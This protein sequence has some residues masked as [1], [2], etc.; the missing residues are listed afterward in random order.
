[1]VIDIKMCLHSVSNDSPLHP[2]AVLHTGLHTGLQTGPLILNDVC[3]ENI[4]ISF[5]QS[6]KDLIIIQHETMSQI[7]RIN[8]TGVNLAWSSS[9]VSSKKICSSRKLCFLF[10]QNTVFI[11]ST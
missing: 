11:I 3:C 10:H 6:Q 4:C 8:N 2:G 9:C 1:M 7:P 5:V